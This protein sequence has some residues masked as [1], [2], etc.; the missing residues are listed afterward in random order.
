MTILIWLIAQIAVLAIMYFIMRG[1]TPRAAPSGEI[2]R[3]PAA[4]GE[5]RELIELKKLRARKLNMPLS[6]KARPRRMEDVIG[7]Q[8]GIRALRAAMCGPNPQHVLIYGP[9]GIGKTCAARL[10]LEE[11][12]RCADSP[13]DESS[14]FIEMDATCVRFDERAIAD[15]LLGSVHD[16][17]YQ[18]AGVLGAQGIPQPK[19]GAVTKAHCGVLFL[20]EIGEL[21]PI[22]LNKLLKVLEDRRVFLESAYYS[23]DNA[24]IPQHIHD[25]FQN[26]LP[27]DFRLIGAT[28]RSPDEMPPA[29]RSR[30]VELF[31]NPLGQSEL[32]KITAGALERLG[33]TM[34]DECA[35]LCASYC[36]SGRD[37]VNIVQLAG[38][39]AHSKGRGEILQSDI[40]W[41]AK[42]CR[43][44]KRV[45]NKMPDA[46]RPGVCVGLGV[47]GANMQGVIIEIE[48]AA[49]KAEAGRGKLTLGGMVE[50]EALETRGRKL[51]RKGT[52]LVSAENVLEVF[53]RRFNVE[54]Q[55]YDV[56][57]NVPGGM[58]LDGPSAGI[59]L[60]VALMSA[61]TGVAPR[62]K[63]ALTGEVTASGEVRPVGG[64]REKIMAAIEAGAKLVVIPKANHDVTFASL[65]AEIVE[66]E[67]ISFVMR[68]AFDISGENAAT[69]PELLVAAALSA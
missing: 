37:A 13:F 32:E 61:L 19:P 52:A 42:T 48:C 41:V 33:L 39:A 6:E 21:H 65:G 50:E 14:R 27:A 31:F 7:Q 66:V 12:K 2:K 17:I 1:R 20:D 18:G 34:S 44:A 10:V 3:T 64:V 4:R 51:V 58:P 9:P 56:R 45:P 43:H 40:L 60:C 28:T 49:T 69:A 26:G 29:L 62:E 23:P 30:C 54:C 8:D 67:D 15:P 46:P 11:A 25:I 55:N 47:A 36:A 5:T 16:P 59:A 22:Q 35:R 57:F 53:R 38:G 68:A 24:H 63:L